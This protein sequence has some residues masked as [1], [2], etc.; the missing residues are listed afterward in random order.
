MVKKILIG[1]LVVLVMIQF[2]RPARNQSKAASPNDITA[3][4]TLP[5]D[6]N[7]IL[8]RSCNDCHSNYTD[9]PGYA[10]IQPLGFWLQNHI[11]EGKAELNFSEFGTYEKKKQAHKLE[12]VAEQVEAGEMPLGNYTAMHKEAKLSKEDAIILVNWAKGLQKQIE[13]QL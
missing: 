4:Y 10:N 7:Q 13:A 12:E 2:I 3:V 8:Q 1:L 5:D 11:N 6:V 9:Y